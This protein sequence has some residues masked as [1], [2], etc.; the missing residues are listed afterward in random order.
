MNPHHPCRNLEQNTTQLYYRRIRIP[1]YSGRVENMANITD[2]NAAWPPPPSTSD[3]PSAP[4]STPESFT[5]EGIALTATDDR[6]V[7]DNPIA[8]TASILFW[9][10]QASAMGGSLWIQYQSKQRNQNVWGFRGAA[11]V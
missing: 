5:V 8:R 6:I 1:M 9:I 3:T 2:V 11:V 10:W 7:V 4:P